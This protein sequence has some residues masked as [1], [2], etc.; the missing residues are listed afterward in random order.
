MVPI[1]AFTSILRKNESVRLLLVETGPSHIGFGIG[2]F[3]AE[4]EGVD[5]GITAGGGGLHAEGTVFVVGG[6]GAAGG[7]QLADVLVGIGEVIVV[8]RIGYVTGAQ[9]DI[10]P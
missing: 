3:R 6:D 9:E 8:C 7:Q 10:K 5:G 1:L 4:T 2:V